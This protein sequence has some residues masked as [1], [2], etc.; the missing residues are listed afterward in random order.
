MSTMAQ[1]PKP[2]SFLMGQA[3]RTLEDFENNPIK[4][5]FINLKKAI[6][7][8]STS[9]KPEELTTSQ[10]NA[11]NELNSLLYFAKARHKKKF[12]VVLPDSEKKERISLENLYQGTQ[13]L[14]DDYYIRHF[15]TAERRPKV[16]SP[17]TIAVVLLEGLPSKIKEI[18]KLVRISPDSNRSAYVNKLKSQAK[19]DL[20][21]L[22]NNITKINIAD[23]NPLQR[24]QLKSIQKSLRVISKQDN[25]FQDFSVNV[26]GLL[27]KYYE[28]K[29]IP[30]LWAKVRS[31]FNPLRRLPGTQESA[32]DPDK[33][34]LDGLKYEPKQS[35]DTRYLQAL[36]TMQM[37][38]KIPSRE[39]METLCMQIRTI[40]DNVGRATEITSAQYNYLQQIDAFFEEQSTRQ[41]LDPL[42]LQA[43]I[44]IHN[45]VEQNKGR[46]ENPNIQAVEQPTGDDLDLKL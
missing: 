31:L 39:L 45:I 42:E 7:E 19:L 44:T 15:P 9:L 40:T 27:N 33:S 16:K 3:K 10:Y 20:T 12:R 4:A 22:M 23:L 46:F 34:F 37:Y 32:H 28:N 14:V 43:Y 24:R 26:E 30:R 11:L 8:L 17:K 38:K 1:Q 21:A 25:S 36:S 2:F 13:K 5:N 6:D 18:S 29:K 35:E 41:N